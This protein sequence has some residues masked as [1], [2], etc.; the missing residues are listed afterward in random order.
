MD[1]EKY[2]ELIQTLSLF[3]DNIIPLDLMS[4]QL[5]ENYIDSFGNNYLHYLSNYT[6]K[7]FCFYEYNPSKNEIINEEKFKSLLNQYLNKIKSFIRYLVN[8]NCSIDWLNYEEQTPFDLCLIKQNYYMANE[9][10]NYIEN[11]QSLFDENKINILYFNNCIHEESINFFLKIFTYFSDKEKIT[12]YLERTIDNEGTITP[13]ISFFKDYNQNIYNKFIE[14]VKINIAKYLQKDDKDEYFIMQSDETKNEIM[15]KSV[16]DIN[17]F[18]LAYFYNLFSNLNCLGADLSFAEKAEKESISAFMYLMSYPRIPTFLKF[19]DNINYQ[20]YFGRT[21]LIHLI[22][23]KKNII[24]ISKDVY[25]DT[26]II[27]IGNELIDLSKRDLNGISAFLLCLLNDYY[28]DAKSIYNNS[29][30]KLLSDFNLDF[31]L[32]FIIKL[33]TNKFNQS[34]ILKINEKFENKINYEE[35]DIINKRNLLHYFFMYYSNDFD[36]YKQTLNFVMNLVSDSNKND[37]YNRHCLFYLFIDF[38]G[39]SKKN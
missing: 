39:D 17:S 34:F 33:N 23:N 21:P 29:I 3:E 1:E 28:E 4:E 6:F 36:N 15:I 22:N 26:F 24:N 14:F 7:E 19:M 38:C 32:L 18:C 27:L 16:K 9:M 10:I 30:D 11:Y 37:I 31:L 13:L 25:T 2:H 12:F 35:I 20:D 8:I 5:G